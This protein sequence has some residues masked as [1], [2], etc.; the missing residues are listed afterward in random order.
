MGEANNLTNGQARKFDFSKYRS[1]DIVDK[2]S[3]ILNIRGSFSNVVRT[4]AYLEFAL[5]VVFIAIC[6]LISD[7]AIL[8][9][10]F[11]SV[12]ILLVGIVL[13]V[14]LG[15]L[16]VVH[17]SLANIEGV[18]TILLDSSN[19]AALDFAAMRSGDVEIPSGKEIVTG[20]YEQVI[21]P[22]IEEVVAEA[23]GFLG[24]PILWM[25]RK[26]I[27]AAVNRLLIAAHVEEH[28][29]TDERISAEEL[30][31]A[32][33]DQAVQALSDEAKPALRFIDSAKSVVKSIAGGLRSY[34]IR[35]LYFVF[36]CLLI[37]A[38][39]P[40]AIYIVMFGLPE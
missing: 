31:T 24:K 18:L 30:N 35:P 1:R 33:V 6:I 38:L 15:L 11:L 12:L 29:V 10:V 39:S 32:E 21:M 13:G 34:A 23:F 26:T 17:K 40:I 36:W 4:A 28:G 14:P 37:L 27:G 20:M 9:A 2:L 3:E 19:H 7:L 8:E 16:R 5:F 25:Y 22:S